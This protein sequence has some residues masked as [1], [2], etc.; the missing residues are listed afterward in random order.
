M[1]EGQTTSDL[2]V[3]ALR[4]ALSQGDFAPEDIDLVIISTDT[5]D[6][7]SPSTAS[8]VCHKAGLI[9]AAS[10][11]LNTALRRVCDRAGD[12]DQLHQ[13]QSRLQP[14][15]GHRRVRDESFFWIC[16][17][18][19]NGDAVCRRGRGG[20]AG[21]NHG[22]GTRAHRLQHKNPR[23]VLRLY[24]DL[25]RGDGASG[26]LRTGGRARGTSCSLSRN[27]PRSSIR[28]CGPK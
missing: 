11:D 21:S 15:T 1:T 13:G 7:I 18:K 2:C 3:Y 9:N 6:Y 19:K 8:V 10:F 5:P 20:C 14:C 28:S 12:G 27:S 26:Q 24:G 17:I 16:T 25:R 23:G 22:A 4:E